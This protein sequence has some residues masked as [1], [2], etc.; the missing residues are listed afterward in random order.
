MGSTTVPGKLRDGSVIRSEVRDEL[1]PILVESGFFDKAPFRWI[2]LLFR[3]SHETNLD[4]EF[5]P[6]DKKDG[7]LPMTIELDLRSV[8]RLPREEA[9]RAHQLAAIDALISAA[10]RFGLPDETLWRRK[11]ELSSGRR[12]DAL[13]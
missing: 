6:I 12:D 1:E 3:Y 7:E 9:K 10:Q 5:D 11:A 13:G 4:P 2:G 8:R